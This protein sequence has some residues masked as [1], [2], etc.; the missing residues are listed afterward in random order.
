[1]Y[2]EDSGAFEGKSGP[3]IQL[4]TAPRF[5]GMVSEGTGDE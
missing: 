3:A 1:M 2:G 5:P 4:G